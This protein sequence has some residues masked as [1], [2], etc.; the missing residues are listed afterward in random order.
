[1]LVL[2]INQRTTSECQLHNKIII[3]LKLLA[4]L[5]EMNLCDRLKSPEKLGLIYMISHSFSCRGLKRK[6]N[7]L[8][9]V[10]IFAVR[11][12]NQKY[13]SYLHHQKNESEVQPLICIPQNNSPFSFLTSHWLCISVWLLNALCRKLF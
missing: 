10:L 2:L 13:L 12:G 11:M 6:G 1:M 7:K 3:I 5:I 9:L 4:Y 8:D